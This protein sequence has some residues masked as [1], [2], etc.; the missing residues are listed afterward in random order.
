MNSAAKPKSQSLSKS[1]VK[2]LILATIVFTSFTLVNAQLHQLSL[3]DLLIG[4]RSQKVPLPD[5]NKLLTEA[6]KQRGVTF[7]TTPEIEKELSTTGADDTLLG[8]I[9]EKS[10]AKAPVIEAPK[11]VA[12]PPDYKFYQTRADGFFSKGDLP[13]AAADYAKSIE[14][15]ADNSAAY[16]GRG[17]VN[18]GLKSFDLAVTD[19]DK[20]ISIEPNDANAYYNRG[21]AYE[22]MNETK[23]AAADYQKAVDL[24]PSNEVGKASLKRMQDEIAKTMPAPQPVKP[25]MVAPE[26]LNLGNLSPMEA[27]K[28]VTPV[29]TTIA[30]KS[31]VEGR[32]VVEV[33]L[34]AQGNVTSAK[35]VSGH[36]ML[37]SSAED[38]AS[39]SKFKPAMF[40]GKPIKARG[41]VTYNFSL[42]LAR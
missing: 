20:A 30:Q 19:F 26:F 12:P 21:L 2:F 7:S 6:V 37:R 23:K 24:D 28:M 32:V 3:A 9:R 18:M 25:T 22:K 41:T 13:S 16:V 5:R 15:N 27:T 29:Y 14:M 17:K 39:K 33:E 31:Q 11:V 35:A 38:A 10:A 8:A 42:K 40:D 4:L 34:D 36:Q 1:I